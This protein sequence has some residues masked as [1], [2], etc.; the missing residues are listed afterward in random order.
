MW[1]PEL[2]MK[3]GL[4]LAILGY[5]EGT[6]YTMMMIM[7]IEDFRRALKDI[8]NKVCPNSQLIHPQLIEV[9]PMQP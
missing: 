2:D 5:V 3:I 4:Y 6:M 9:Q 8:Y 7:F 1:T